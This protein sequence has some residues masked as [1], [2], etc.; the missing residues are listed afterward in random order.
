M[1]VL[2]QHLFLA[3]KAY[4]TQESCYSSAHLFVVLMTV[5]PVCPKVVVVSTSALYHQKCIRPEQCY[6]LLC[7]Y[8]F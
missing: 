6:C 7:K 1:A 2:Q 5:T 3:V 4:A 8:L